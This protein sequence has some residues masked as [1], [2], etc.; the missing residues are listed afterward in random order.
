MNSNSMPTFGERC[1][2][3]IFPCCQKEHEH[4]HERKRKNGHKVFVKKST[5]LILPVREAVL[6][7]G[8]WFLREACFRSLFLK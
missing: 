2:K 1:L 3:T 8:I 7:G 6:G 5:R 4:E